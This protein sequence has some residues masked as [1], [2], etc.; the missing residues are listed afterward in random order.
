MSNNLPH[1][2]LYELQGK[3]LQAAKELDN[4]LRTELQHVKV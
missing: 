4:E 2:V 1:N 3:S